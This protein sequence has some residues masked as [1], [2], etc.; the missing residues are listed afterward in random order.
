MVVTVENYKEIITTWLEEKKIEYIDLTSYFKKVDSG[1]ADNMSELELIRYCGEVAA[2]MITIHSKYN[3]FA[4]L[5]LMKHHHS[6]TSNSF[7]EKFLHI[8]NKKDIFADNFVE[9]V[10]RHK[11]QYENMID[12]DRDF[13]FDYFGTISLFKSYLIKVDGNIIERPQDMYM[14][15][16]I[17]IHRD[18]FENVNETYNMLS[19]Q[20]YT[21][22][23][24]TL[25]NS[26]FRKNQMASCFLQAMKD[27]TILGIFETIK[28]SA[29]YSKLSGGIG[30]HLSNL[31]CNNSP[32]VTTGG[33]S[34]G[35]VPIIKL[36]ND[37]M[38]YINQGGARRCS[39]AA[40][41]L[42]PWHKDIFQF[43]DLRKNTGPEDMRARECFTAL[44]I[45][46]LFMERVQA[47]KEWSLFDPN[48]AKGL[49]DVW[50]D[51]FK[52]LYERYERE[53]DRTVVSAQKLWK[54][55]ICSQIETGTP[56]MVY[57]DACNR[58]SNQL[59]M[60]TIKSSNL[61][62]EII[63]YSDADITAICS[64]SSICLPKFISVVGGT[65]I[66]DYH[67]L[68]AASKIVCR[69]LNKMIDGIVMPTEEAERSK[70]Q[71]RAI[72]IG[73][74][75]LA[76]VFF[77]L[78]LPFESDEARKI[79][80]TIFET[81][82]FGS[83]EASCDLAVINGPYPLYYG[84]MY[85]K[86]IF[87][88][89]QYFKFKSETPILSGLWDWENLRERIN[90]HGVSNSLLL[91]CMP[92]ASTAQLCGN[93]ECIEP[94]TSNIYTRRTF[95]GEFQ[96]VNK[97][98]ME[99]LLKLGL[100]SNEMR[101]LIIEY[102]GSIQ[103]I[104]VIPD[105]IKKLYKTVWELKMKRI[106]DLS[107]DRQAFIDQSQSLNIF[108]KQPTYSTLSSMHFYGWKKGLKTGMYYLRTM[109]VASA[110][111]FTVDKE[112]I[113]KTLSSMRNQE[114]DVNKG[115]TCEG[116]SC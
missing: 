41:Y 6:T 51:D 108:I 12:Y 79:N 63:Q 58:N 53:K 101:Q 11:D 116:C 56:Y 32:L 67:K 49:N 81:I 4:A 71:T 98:L 68:Y 100:W 44:Y 28:E 114:E 76:D 20:W 102:N 106:L 30:L 83:L 86:G 105:N 23:T 35:I 17:Q 95:A 16:A 88:F 19:N 64:L 75:G 8:Q 70:S 110:I 93:S 13:N 77:S 36:I 43:L 7:A 15:V 104:P 115:P 55:I 73:V 26:C 99:D 90:R 59:N 111:K 34:K 94:V 78:G 2:S 54:E 96:M 50:G 14:R 62:A 29:I 9:L 66:F 91:A 10:Q 84:S 46:D 27:D 72:G 65:K 52:E 80:R 22:A 45:N 33:V 25:Y 21:H 1:L 112:L 57:K 85:S 38:K 37:A 74:Q 42:E 89:E 103:D 3:D 69:D 87:H 48:V 31:R 5:I 47:D 82:Y 18:D 97:F 24:P 113:A 61:C 109:P 60:G 40:F 92:T 107:D 39:T